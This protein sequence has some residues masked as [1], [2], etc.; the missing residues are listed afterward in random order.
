MDKKLTKYAKTWSPQNM[1]TYPTVQTITDNT[2][3]TYQKQRPWL[4]ILILH[5]FQQ[6]LFS[7]WSLLFKPGAR[8]PLDN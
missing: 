6:G 5:L 3:L 2:L 4:P 8:Q 1:Q 7:T